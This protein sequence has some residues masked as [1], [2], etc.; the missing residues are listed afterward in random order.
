MCTCSTR[1][2]DCAFALQRAYSS[3]RALA[4]H[5]HAI[6]LVC[7][8]G[9][10]NL[11]WQ[12]GARITSARGLSLQMSE[13]RKAGRT[14][15]VHDVFSFLSGTGISPNMRIAS[16]RQH[17]KT[18]N[19]ST[20]LHSH[21][22]ALFSMGPLQGVFPH[23]GL[24]HVTFSGCYIYCCICNQH[25]QFC[26]QCWFAQARSN[27]SHPTDSEGSSSSENYKALQARFV[28]RFQ[29]QDPG[30]SSERRQPH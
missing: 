24:H 19:S 28:P 30:H 11:S 4:H 6:A 5:A 12:V 3:I 20:F 7:A 13:F 10:V 8:L 15:T 26:S 23:R 2:H 25:S 18:H 14:Q 22:L 17:S 16:A 29:W 9:I 21:R 27:M 1:A